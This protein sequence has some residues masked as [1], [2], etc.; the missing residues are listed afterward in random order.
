MANITLKGNF[1]QTVGELPKAGSPS[2]D[3]RLTRGELTD[4][5][6]AGF[7]GK[8]EILI[9]VPTLDTGAASA[10]ARPRSSRPGI[11]GSGLKPRAILVAYRSALEQREG[12]NWIAHP[13]APSRWEGE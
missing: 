6:L 2:P 8:V 12:L 11:P 13:L 4:I 1:I 3:V 10:G 7:E 5:S 9:I